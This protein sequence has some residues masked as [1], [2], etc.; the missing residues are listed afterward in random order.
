MR[1]GSR[2]LTP[3]L[4]LVLSSLDLNVSIMID[5]LLEYVQACTPG[6]FLAKIFHCLVAARESG[7]HRG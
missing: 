6:F 7:T 4:S 1:V 3:V 2:L 5:N